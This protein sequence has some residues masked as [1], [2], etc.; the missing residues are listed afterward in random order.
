M[1]TLVDAA[2]PENKLKVRSSRCTPWSSFDSFGG[3]KMR[4]FFVVG[5]FQGFVIVLHPLI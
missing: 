2:K 5:T 1:L 3:P 4:L